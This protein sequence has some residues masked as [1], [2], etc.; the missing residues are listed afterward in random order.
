MSPRHLSMHETSKPILLISLGTSQAVVPE[1]FLLPDVDFAEVHVLTTA[2]PRIEMVMSWFRDRYPDVHLTLTRAIEFVDFNSEE[3]HFRFEEVLYRWYLQHSRGPLPWVCLAG[4][5]KTIAASMQ[6][7]AALFGAA[8][9]FHVICDPI[10]SLDG[11]RDVYPENPSEILEARD[12]G[13]LHWI[14]LG[15][16]SGWPQLRHESS[17]LFPLT[18]SWSDAVVCN[19]QAPDLQLTVRVRSLVE[20]SQNIDSAWERMADLPFPHLATWAP[21]HL[22]WLRRSVEPTGDMEWITALPK[23]ELHCHLGGFATDGDDLQAVRAAASNPS[24]LPLLMPPEF[25]PGWPRPL[26]PVSLAQYMKLGDAN[27]TKLLRDPGCLQRQCELLYSHFQSQ[28]VLYAEVRCS[29]A[30]YTDPKLGRS[31]WDVLSEVRQ[32]F[33]TAIKNARADGSWMCHVNLILIATRRDKTEKRDFRA[34]ISRHL[35]LAVSAAEHWTSENECRVV[36]VDLAGYESTETRA[37]YFREEFTGVHRCGLALTVHAGENDDAEGIWRAVFDLNARRLGHALHLIDSPELMRSVADR[38]IGVEMCPY[39][40]SQ[41]KGFRPPETGNST[42]LRYPLKKYLDEGIRATVNTDNIGISSANLTENLQLASIL[43][44][45]LT[46]L[47]LLRIQF[48]AIQTAFISP[49]LR[50]K[51]SRLSAIHLPRP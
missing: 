12:Q 43:C 51:F 42:S 37:H 15:P 47:D 4:G 40:N 1:A 49:G 11:K 33:S 10:R 46:R 5:F 45:E 41:I 3:D 27:G 25:I 38:G 19:A 9:V 48:N 36:G 22:D 14:R 16:E 21:A 29:P 6:K 2:R 23:V 17:E 39:A 13:R 31:P 24:T 8:E 18:K 28:R 32:H 50:E 34:A 44:P 30:N 26:A 7:T 20:R 35:A